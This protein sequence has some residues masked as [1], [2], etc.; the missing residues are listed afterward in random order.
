[1]AM[2]VPDA[3]SASNATTFVHDLQEQPGLQ[4]EAEANG[5]AAAADAAGFDLEA[6]EI[7]SAVADAAAADLPEKGSDPEDVERR[8]HSN[9]DYTCY[10]TCTNV[11]CDTSSVCY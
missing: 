4:A 9:C 11:G 10:A 5:L 2:T 1:M 3:M 7:A 6:D 8:T